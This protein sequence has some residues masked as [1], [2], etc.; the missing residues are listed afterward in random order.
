MINLN[1]LIFSMLK[2]LI[3]LSA[4]TI[5]F[6]THRHHVKTLLIVVYFAYVIILGV[7]LVSDDF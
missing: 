3:D 7:V 4:D 2:H 6:Y 1:G 5:V